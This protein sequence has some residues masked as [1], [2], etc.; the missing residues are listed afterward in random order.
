MK[1]S[2]MAW[3]ILGVLL[4]WQQGGGV[5]A[6]EVGGKV[7]PRQTL[8]AVPE[9][10][11]TADKNDQLA[12]KGRELPNPPAGRVPPYVMHLP[13]VSGTS[14]VDHTLRAGMKAAGFDGPFEIYDWTCHDPGIPA[15][16]NRVRNER[17]AQI[18]A[19]RITKQFHDKP[20]QPIFVTCHSGGVGP[21]VWALE[22]LPADVKV[23][24][25]IMLAPAMSPQYDL[26]KALSHV[27]DKAYCYWSTG[28]DLVLGTGTKIFGTIDGV[29]CEAAGKVGFSKPTMP[30]D[31]KQYDKLVSKPYEAEW[32]R[33]GHVGGHVGWMAKSF[34]QI[35]VAPGLLGK[36]P[37]KAEIEAAMRGVMPEMDVQWPK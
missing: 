27:T 12:D 19:D 16:H 36:T 20:E 28:D 6:D 22:K 29:K 9:P 10:I 24:S 26:S 5:L 21:A 32:A 11:K 18:V 25:F 34:I 33:L 3:L 17:Q 30:A 1:R 31:A 7:T 8:P 35:V 14:I 37:T 4:G 15:L 13:G 23:H 2:V